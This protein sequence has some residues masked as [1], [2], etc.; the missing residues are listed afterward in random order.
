MVLN[1][2]ELKGCKKEVLGLLQ[3]KQMGIV[4][5]PDS[6]VIFVDDSLVTLLETIDLCTCK[7]CKYTERAANGDEFDCSVLMVHTR[8]QAYDLVDCGFGCNRFEPKEP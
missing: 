8:E 7:N 2:N 3:R 5:E 1:R 6:N 4:Y